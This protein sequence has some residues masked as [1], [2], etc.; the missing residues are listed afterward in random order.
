MACFHWSL[1][2]FAQT[3]L[4]LLST[5]TLKRTHPIREMS[6]TRSSSTAT[7][8]DE[9]IEMPVNRLQRLQSS[10]MQASPASRSLVESD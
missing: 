1:A 6:R 5:P 3:V 9:R 4:A 2:T 7:C 8:R 10:F